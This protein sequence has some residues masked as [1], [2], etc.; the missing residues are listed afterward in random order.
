MSTKDETHQTPASDTTGEAIPFDHIW[1]GVYGSFNET[2]TTGEGF[3]SQRW[4]NQSLKKVTSLLEQAKD[5]SSV[6]STVVHRD[7]LLPFLAS[8][9]SHG[10]E[11]I[12]ILDLGGGLGLTFVSVSQSVDPQKDFEYHIV[13]LDTICEIG[14]EL[15]K[16]DDRIHFHSS[17]PESISAVDIVHMESALQYVGE[18]E[19]ILGKLAEYNAEFFLFT[20][21]AA[22]DIPTYATTQQYYES[23]IPYWFFNLDEVVTAVTN[24]GYSLQFKSTYIHRILGEEQKFPQDNFPEDLRLGHSCNLLFRRTGAG[25]SIV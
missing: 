21:L 25:R 23:R 17:L 16:D 9:I 20:N 12:S 19:D 18:W 6:P 4:V 24:L 14:T 22:G 5:S 10:S 1:D 13:D 11:R 15:F 3:R 7:N 8:L 2:P